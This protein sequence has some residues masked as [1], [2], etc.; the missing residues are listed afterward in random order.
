MRSRS[1]QG[2]RIAVAAVTL[3]APAWG[4]RS[5]D[6]LTNTMTEATVNG[7][8][9]RRNKPM[10]RG[11][12]KFKRTPAD[13]SSALVRTAEIHRDGSYEVAAVVGR[14]L[15]EVSGPRF[16]ASKEFNVQEGTNRFDVTLP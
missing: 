15:V 7:T 9:K 2:V 13:R 1:W 5:G 11:L 10:T 6:A 4:C 14:N 12:V 16:Y 8:V 3:L